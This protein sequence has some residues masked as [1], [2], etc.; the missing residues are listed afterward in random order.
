MAKKAAAYDLRVGC[1]DYLSQRKDAL[2]KLDISK[3]ARMVKPTM[4]ASHKFSASWYTPPDGLPRRP[5]TAEEA[6]AGAAREWS[7][8]M[9]EPPK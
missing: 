9:T 2:R 5:A 6:R 4:K 8:V 7:K 1:T 3:S